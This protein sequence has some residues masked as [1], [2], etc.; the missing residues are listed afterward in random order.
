MVQKEVLKENKGDP[1][2]NNGNLVFEV[3]KGPKGVG[4]SYVV[5]CS[6][7]IEGNVVANMYPGRTVSSAICFDH[8]ANFLK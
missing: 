6:W 4:I 7:C 2:L 8:Y 5:H 3:R 1:R